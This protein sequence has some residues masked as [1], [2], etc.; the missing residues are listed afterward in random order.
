M[1]KYYKKQQNKQTNKIPSALPE[2]KQQSNNG[3]ASKYLILFV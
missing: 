3:R 1:T 2:K